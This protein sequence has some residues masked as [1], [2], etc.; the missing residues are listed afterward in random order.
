M[1]LKAIN[2]FLNTSLSCHLWLIDNSPTD[3]LKDLISDSRVT[4][5]HN[6]SNP[7]F[8]TSHNIAFKRYEL[9]SKYH[10]IL[11]PDIYYQPGVVEELINFLEHDKTIGVV[12]P[13]VL[14]P[15]GDIQY[16]AKLLPN[17]FTFFIRRLVPSNYLKRRLNQK[18]EL[19]AS[20]YNRIMD[21]PFLSGCFLLFNTNVFLK[22]DGFD[23]NIFM[24]TED[25]DVCRRVM[26]AGYRS[27]FFPM[28]NV[29]H[30]HL[31]KSFTNLKTLKVYLKS[32]IYYF[33]KWGW[34]YDKQRSVIN[35]HTL[36]ELSRLPRCPETI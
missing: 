25:I 17:P 3:E 28:V 32:T 20:G 2:S 29:Y 21:V 31:T 26:D 11:N 23:T 33:N 1:L 6:P 13:K 24:Y 10:L 18:F 35:K 8:G 15:S 36:A 34:F 9:F 14:Y 4:Y 12:M 19:R 5:F 7:G 30:D 27:V 22:I 16:L